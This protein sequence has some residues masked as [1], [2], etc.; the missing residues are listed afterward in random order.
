MSLSAA[1]VN[2]DCEPAASSTKPSQSRELPVLMDPL[3]RF[4]LIGRNRTTVWLRSF[5]R[6]NDTWLNCWGSRRISVL[7]SRPPNDRFL[8]VF[9][10]KVNAAGPELGG[11][12]LGGGIS[13]G[14]GC[15]AKFQSRPV[16]IGL[17]DPR[18]RIA[19][20][21]IV[22][23]LFKTCVGFL[24]NPTGFSCVTAWAEFGWPTRGSR[25][26]IRLPEARIP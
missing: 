17:V 1:S 4:S 24:G 9:Y 5:T 25:L 14:E 21:D 23:V 26:Q 7:S 11:R 19:E 13:L 8:L 20:S 10:L 12:R 2:H 15:T 18:A 3:S 6:R 22:V 16:Q